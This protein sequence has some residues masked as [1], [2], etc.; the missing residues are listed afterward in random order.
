MTEESFEGAFF[1]GHVFPT[2]IG[3]TKLYNQKQAAHH[4]SRIAKFKPNWVIVGG[5]SGPGARPVMQEWV[6]DIRN[7]TDLRARAR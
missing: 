5:E 6:T 4:A 1:F 2:K 3:I 7:H